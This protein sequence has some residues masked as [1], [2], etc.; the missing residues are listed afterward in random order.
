VNDVNANQRSNEVKYCSRTWWGM[1][2]EMHVCQRIDGVE[3]GDQSDGP[4]MTSFFLSH[5]FELEKEGW[6]E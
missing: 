1:Q 2:R 5:W 3:Y 4:E 6:D